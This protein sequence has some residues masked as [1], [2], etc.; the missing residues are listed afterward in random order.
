MIHTLLPRLQSTRGWAIWSEQFHQVSNFPRRSAA[1]AGPYA[2]LTS[3]ARAN[4]SEDDYISV[5]L[6]LMIS[7]QHSSHGHC[8]LQLSILV[9]MQRDDTP[10]SSR[11][12]MEYTGIKKKKPQLDAVSRFGHGESMVTES[13][14]NAPIYRLHH[15]QTKGEPAPC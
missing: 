14:T 6:E 4:T 11:W 10:S 7:I 13:R 3:Y 2:S 8:R 15:R 12:S 1:T 5:C 9:A